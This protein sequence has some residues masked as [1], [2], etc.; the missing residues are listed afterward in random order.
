VVSTAIRKDNPE[1]VCAYERRIP[2]VRRA[3]MLAELM[4]LKNTSPSPAP[5]ARRRPL[6]DRDLLDAGGIDPTVINGGIINAYGS[7]A[8]LGS[9]DWMVV[10][11]DESDGSFLRL[12]GTIAVVT[13]IDPE[14]SR[15]LWQLRQG[16]GRLCRVRRERAVLRRRPALRRPSRGADHH[17][18]AARP[19]GGAIRLRRTGRCP[20]RERP[21]RARRQPLRRD[22]PRPLGQGAHDPRHLLADA[23]AP[24]RLERAGGDRSRRRARH[25]GRH[26]RQGFERFGGVKRRFTKVGDIQ[27]ATIIDDYGHHPTEI[28]AVLSAAA[29]VRR[30]G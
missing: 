17:P 4:R 16:Q 11:A 6:D 5:T 21:A 8:R 1:L 29:R 15:P 23:R 26:H 20:R 28:R 30:A 2:V 25:I 24:Q 9:S 14:Q 7:N 19:A 12:D 10:E 27:G 18:A 22:D 13:N 3:E